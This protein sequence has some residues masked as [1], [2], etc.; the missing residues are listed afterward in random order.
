MGEGRRVLAVWAGVE[1]DIPEP[2]RV[3]LCDVICQVPQAGRAEA[4]AVEA[5]A[6]GGVL[7]DASLGVKSDKRS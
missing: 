7:A 2:V 3:H 4:G 1:G 5:A 6:H